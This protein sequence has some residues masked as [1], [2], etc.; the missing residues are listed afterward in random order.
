MRVGDLLI[1]R[2][3]FQGLVNRSNVLLSQECLPGPSSQE[4]MSISTPLGACGD[5]IGYW[6]WKHLVKN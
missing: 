5:Y 2:I 6:T 3:L 1:N 4:Y